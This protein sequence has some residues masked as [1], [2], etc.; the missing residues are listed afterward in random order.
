MKSCNQRKKCNTKNETGVIVSDE[1]ENIITSFSHFARELNLSVGDIVR[2]SPVNRTEIPDKMA[3]LWGGVRGLWLS[4]MEDFNNPRLNCLEQTLRQSLWE[5][6]MLVA[7]ATPWSI[8]ELDA[9]AGFKM[10]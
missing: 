1:M 3:R 2:T 7:Q 8:D 10:S 5:W 6:V 9:A 4:S